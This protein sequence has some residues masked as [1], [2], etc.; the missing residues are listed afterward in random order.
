MNA[1]TGGE[2]VPAAA[3]KGRP[4]DATW[5]PRLAHWPP[6]RSPATDHATAR[7]RTQL[8]AHALPRTLLDP[9]DARPG[10][11]S[12]RGIRVRHLPRAPRRPEHQAG[13]EGR[14]GQRRR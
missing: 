13:G 11:R 14:R 5:T 7:I 6:I 8:H 2:A 9:E 10:P 12:D 1:R 3:G 4:P